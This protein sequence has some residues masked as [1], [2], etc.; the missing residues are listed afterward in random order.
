[1]LTYSVAVSAVLAGFIQQ[2]AGADNIFNRNRLVDGRSS[3]AL[4][5]QHL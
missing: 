2:I 5:R 3:F 1:M 4:L